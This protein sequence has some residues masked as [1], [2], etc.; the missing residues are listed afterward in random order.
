MCA[1]FFDPLIIFLRIDQLHVKK[2]E[3]MSQ[4]ILDYRWQK[5][6]HQSLIDNV[7]GDQ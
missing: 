6:L 1:S 4:Q 5:Y 2:C 3:K 7:I